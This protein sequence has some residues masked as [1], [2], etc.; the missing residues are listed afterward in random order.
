MSETLKQVNATLKK[1]F[2]GKKLILGTGHDAAKIV[3]VCEAPTTAEISEKK[4]ITGE[5]EKMLNK[6]LKLAGIDKRKIYMT[7]VIKYLVDGRVHT[8]KEIKAAVPFLKDELKTIKPDIV[9]TLGPTALNG[10]GLRLPL[11]NAHGRV[12]NMGSYDLVPTFHPGHA[13]KD[14]WTNSLLQADFMKLKEHIKNKKN[15]PEESFTNEA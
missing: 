10:V 12:F 1:K 6:L 13:Q 14:Q 3:F 2:S 9:V 4:P 8:P 15:Q 5:S 11:D 7:S